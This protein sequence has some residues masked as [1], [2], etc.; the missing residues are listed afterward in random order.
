MVASS[1][2]SFFEG[3]G[4]GKIARRSSVPFLGT[5]VSFFLVIRVHS[6]VG[7][8]GNEVLRVSEFVA[9]DL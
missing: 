5:L 6:F 1:L 9:L 7:E 8:V 3:K 4:A 2:P